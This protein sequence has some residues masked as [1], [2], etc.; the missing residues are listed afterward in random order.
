MK[1][2]DFRRNSNRKVSATAK[3]LIGVASLAA[4]ASPLGYAAD[5]PKKPDEP[6][7]E[8][9]KK[10][11]ESSNEE[12]RN[13]VDVT[14][15]GNLVD[16]DKAAF[17][18]R[19]GQP[20]DVWGGVADFHYEQDV[21][22]KGLFEVDGR[23]IFDAHDYSITLGYKDPDKFYVRGGYEQFRTYYDLSGG[24]FPGNGQFIDLYS[25][26]GEIDREK[27]FFE[28]GLT[29][30]NKPQVRVRY[31]YDTREGVKNSTSWGDSALIGIAGQVRKIVPSLNDIDESHHSIALDISHVIGKTQAGIGGRYDFYT[32]DNARLERRNAL[33]PG[34]IDRSITH[35]EGVDTDLFNAHAW[36]DTDFT[37]KVKLTTGYSYTK[38][39][40]DLSG[41]RAI[42]ATFYADPS[43]AALAA[44][45][46]KQNNDEGFYGLAGGSGI[47]QHVGTISLMYR[48]T[49][50]LTIVPSLRIE[51]QDQNGDASFTS[52]VVSSGVVNSE[53]EQNSRHR[54]FL[55]IAESIDIRYS[56]VTNWV[57]YTRAELLE[58]SGTLRETDRIL[59]DAAT[60]EPLLRVT[61]S[62]RFTQKYSIGANWY[63]T[64]KINLAT[65]YYH[66]VR[67][68]QYDHREDP[69]TPPVTPPLAQG[70]Y[71]AFIE[72]QT[73]TTE[74]ANIRVTYKPLA[75]LSFV[76]RYDFQYTTIDSD[77]E[78]LPEVEAG[79]STAHIITESITWMPINRM[80]VT[81]GGSYALDRLSSPANDILPRLQVSKNN[82]YTANGTVGYALTEKT[83]VS[84]NYIYYMSDNYEPSIAATG[85]PYGASLAEHVIGG[86][87]T[88]RFNRRMQ[89][90][91][92]YA[93]MTSHDET[94]GGHNDFDGHLM[95]ATL[96][97]RF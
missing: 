44:F 89:L 31:D 11:E 19:T 30:E 35:R 50:T 71:P 26:V 37:D 25:G 47:N 77:M 41:D 82:Y 3:W 7:K 88:H 21:G 73:F 48:P 76:T 43:Q 69:T 15:G 42:G 13:W 32:Y 9:E 27:V 52:L 96:R 93:F 54:D 59:V 87:I 92:R 33:E 5:E 63:P 39:E 16:G 24:Y 91:A 40:S 6:K 83:D 79:R 46:N 51:S 49:P 78:L 68:N 85:M 14:V 62:D 36:T 17:Q 70:Y 66:R 84:V 57:F 4:L 60:G 95:S 22:K 56:G 81:V 75:N 90:T 12:L 28:A 86:T 72:S 18:Q 55:D 8:E 53:F 2:K 64:R 23:G 20:R 10:A 1:S 74:D 58:G 67:D 80:Y 38:L 29:L 94:S 65:Q 97:Y 61:D 45:P 34:T